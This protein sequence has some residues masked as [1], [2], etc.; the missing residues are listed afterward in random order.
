MKGS[1]A[2]LLALLESRADGD[3][4]FFSRDIVITG[5]TAAVVTLRNLL[6]RDAV[7]VFATAT[8]LFGPFD[9][10]V[11]RAAGALDRRLLA[12]RRH[13]AAI[14]ADLHRDM[15][16]DRVLAMRAE[17]LDADIRALSARVAKLEARN[18]RHSP[19]SAPAVDVT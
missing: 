3:A 10:L 1:L 8:G 18:R 5:D 17:R 15:R 9:G 13:L 6:E 7:D 2:A 12:V 19:S 14:H 16:D 4:L 11:R